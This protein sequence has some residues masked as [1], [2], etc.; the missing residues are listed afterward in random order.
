MLFL[1]R[2]ALITPPISLSAHLAVAGASFVILFAFYL[3]GWFG[4]GD[5][6]LITALM[7]WAG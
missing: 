5:A 7:L 4:A 3:L 6:K 2:Y 1:A